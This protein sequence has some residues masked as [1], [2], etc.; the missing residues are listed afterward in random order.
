MTTEQLDRL[1]H[2][3]N[4]RIAYF[5]NRSAAQHLRAMRHNWSRYVL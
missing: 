4:Q 3:A 2:E 5:V 1:C